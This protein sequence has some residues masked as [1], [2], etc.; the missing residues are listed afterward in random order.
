MFAWFGLAILLSG[1]LAVAVVWTLSPALHWRRHV[2]DLH[3]FVSGRFAAEWE[4]PERRDALARAVADDLELGIVLNDAD[5]TE[6]T[7]HG[8]PCERRYAIPIRR[9]DV[10]LGEAAFCAPV[11]SEGPGP[12]WWALGAGAFVLWGVAGAIAYRIA[13]P[14]SRLA[15][16]T[17]EIGDGNL[18]VDFAVG[19]RAVD[20][21]HEL[22]GAMDEMLARIRKQVG[23][24]GE[25][26]AAV[27]HEIRTPLGHLRILIDLAR[28]G[29]SH[30]R[31]GEIEREVLA[32][33]TIVGQ[34]VANS[35]IEFGTLDKREL[36][37]VQ[38]ALLALERLGL[39]PTLLEASDER[40]PLMADA[41]L[42][43]SALTNM[44]HNARDHGGGVQSL[45]VQ[46]A[47]EPN[48][49]VP[50]GIPTGSVVRF[51]VLDAG[52]GFGDAPSDAFA[53]FSRGA[54]RSGGSLG[55]GL[56]LV[57]RIAEAHDGSVWASDR[58]E[59]G[60]RVGFSC[61]TATDS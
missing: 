54:N 37:A 14:L 8:A 26:L 15:E 1:A 22:A 49:A 58:P 28:E 27:S 34:L 16:A 46:R 33:D 50:D 23:D 5:G 60:A 57:R 41:A 19:P 48:D 35:R 45:R 56:A 52:P 2:D 17:R 4:T 24:Q 13:R 47:D 59:G 20:E 18:D 7:R 44:L 12:L 40:L 9:D 11:Y 36:D 51:E 39:S 31:L 30:S 43:G 10:V 6:L 21:V 53:A 55:L 32:I 38:V 29:D 25:L 3:T 61:H 42:V